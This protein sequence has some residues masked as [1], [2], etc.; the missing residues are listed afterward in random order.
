M[1]D[2]HNLAYTLLEH[3]Y[4]EERAAVIWAIW[5]PAERNEAAALVEPLL[6]IIQKTIAEIKRLMAEVTA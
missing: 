1:S 2:A 6:P 3:G 5:T 4:G